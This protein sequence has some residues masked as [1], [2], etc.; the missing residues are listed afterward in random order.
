MLQKNNTRH[1]HTDNSFSDI[2]TVKIPARGLRFV[3][4][5][6]SNSPQKLR[7]IAHFC[8]FRAQ[9]RGDKQPVIAA[10]A[11]LEQDQPAGILYP[12][13]DPYTEEGERLLSAN[14]LMTYTLRGAFSQGRVR[15]A[16][17]QW[18]ATPDASAREQVIIT[19]LNQAQRLFLYTGPNSAPPAA[20]EFHADSFDVARNFIPVDRC[21]TVSDYAAHHAPLLA[22]NTAFFFIGIR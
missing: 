3:N 4:V 15:Y 2:L 19:G 12:D 6:Q 13:V 7:E 9:K 18:I 14:S 20:Q 21:G 17:G 11:R 22:F 5:D 10:Y 1:Y 16:N 8:Y